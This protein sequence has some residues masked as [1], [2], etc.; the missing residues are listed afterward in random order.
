MSHELDDESWAS[1][2]GNIHETAVAISHEEKA[3]RE[4]QVVNMAM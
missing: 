1:V 2:N 3:R 4:P